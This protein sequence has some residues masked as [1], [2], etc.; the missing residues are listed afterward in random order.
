MKLEQFLSMQVNQEMSYEDAQILNEDL[1]TKVISN[2]PEKDRS[3]VADY[4]VTALNMHSVKSDLIPK[5]DLLLS[6]LQEA[7]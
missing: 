4:L 5:L 1:A 2:I 6:S 7:A 3:L